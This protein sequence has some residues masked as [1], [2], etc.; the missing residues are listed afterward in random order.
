MCFGKDQRK[1]K[2]NNAIHT[3]S[4]RLMCVEKKTEAAK[5]KMNLNCTQMFFL[6]CSF[7]F[8]CIFD[9]S[10]FVLTISSSLSNACNA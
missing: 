4:K 10:N 2:R 1:R 3:K 7:Y 9:L 6:E 8:Y 5:S